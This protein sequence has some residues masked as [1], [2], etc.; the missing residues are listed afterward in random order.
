MTLHLTDNGSNAGMLKMAC[1]GTKDATAFFDYSFSTDCLPRNFSKSEIDRCIKSSHWHIYDDCNQQILNT[2]LDDYDE[3]IVWHSMDANSLLFLY[4]ICFSAK[5]DIWHCNVSEFYGSI[6][7]GQCTPGQINDLYYNL[8]VVKRC[9]EEEERLKYCQIY[10]SLQETEG[11]PKI[12]DGYHIIP[13][14]KDFLKALLLKN[15]TYYGRNYNKVIRTTIA[16]SPI[17]LFFSATYFDILLFEMIEDKILEPVK[18]DRV[19]KTRNWRIGDYYNR[20]YK[21]HDEYIN[22]WY[23]FSVR[24]P[25][26]DL[27]EYFKSLYIDKYGEERSS[28]TFWN[29]I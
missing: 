24:K 19:G 23:T 6:R 15:I 27:E 7:T 18:I 12:S 2:N 29:R 8:E 21:Y 9:I 4:F 16:N 3:I 25:K 20:K 26:L 22:D 14:S 13:V 17:Q 10:Q 28:I 11:I 1:Q 5:R